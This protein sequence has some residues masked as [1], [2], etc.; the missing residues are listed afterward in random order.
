MTW[1]LVGRFVH[2]DVP[3]PFFDNWVQVGLEEAK[4]FELLRNRLTELGG[5]YGD[6]PAHAGL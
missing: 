2:A 3:R 5:A 6:L 4:H 1:D